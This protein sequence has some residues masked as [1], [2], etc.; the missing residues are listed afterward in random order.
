MD[1]LTKSSQ[2]WAIEAH[3]TKFHRLKK[4]RTYD[5]EHYRFSESPAFQAGS[6]GRQE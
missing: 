5:G 4:E 3:K 6:L 1:N 2:D